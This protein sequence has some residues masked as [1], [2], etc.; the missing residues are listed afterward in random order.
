MAG[1]VYYH[2]FEMFYILIS[3]SFENNSICLGAIS[4]KE[5]GE[6]LSR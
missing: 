2:H 6:V 4:V 3:E 1:Q 5:V